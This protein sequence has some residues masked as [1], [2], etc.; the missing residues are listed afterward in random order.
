MRLYYH[1]FDDGSVNF[2][3]DLN[4]WLWNRLLPGYFDDDDETT[5]VGIGTLLNE[6]LPR[7]TPLAKRRLIFSTGL[8]YGEKTFELGPDY[9]VYCVRGA[10]SAWKLGLDPEAAVTDGALLIRRVYEPNSTKTVKFSF[11]P[12]IERIAGE[13]WKSI[14]DELGFGYID[15]RGSTEEVLKQICETEVL[16]TEAMH[17]AIVADALRVPWVPLV[18]SDKI[19]SFKWQDWCGSVDVAYKPIRI[20]EAFNLRQKPGDPMALA[21]RVRYEVRRKMAL[22]DLQKVSR[23]ALPCL[24]KE[25][26]LESLTCELETRLAKLQ[27]DNRRCASAA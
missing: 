27:C 5:F 12:H 8:G 7:R 20:A 10:L 16:L 24:S 11:M 9:T 22:H 6:A 15:P 13:A 17:G 2:G 18:T 26:N 3:D 19:L 23:T 21:R 25:S 14:C 1:K 4:A